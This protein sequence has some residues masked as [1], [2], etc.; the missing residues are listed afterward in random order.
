MVL[1]VVPTLGLGWSRYGHHGFQK[2]DLA[3]RCR[4][5]YTRQKRRCE[6][7]WSQLPRSAHLTELF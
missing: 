4:V 6:V 1:K 2:W 5:H 7:S 3:R